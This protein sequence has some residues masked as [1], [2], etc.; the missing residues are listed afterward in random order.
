MQRPQIIRFVAFVSVLAVLL[1]YVVYHRTAS[2]VTPVAKSRTHDVTGAQG[3]VT[4]LENYFV[5][6]RMQ[7]DQMMSREV[8]TIQ[9]LLK[10][11]GLST[12][13]KNEAATTLVRDQRELKQETSIEGLLAAHG[14]PLAA[15]TISGNRADIV[16]GAQ[17][18]T[19]RQ[20][21]RI[22]DTVTQVTSLPPENVVIFPKG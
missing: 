2:E 6:Y 7:R 11:P 3:G 12:R 13:A 4:R 9:N 21:A 8:S 16:I 18:L 10:Q 19:A 5:N 14:F 22:A 17:S 15:A 1:G 20:V